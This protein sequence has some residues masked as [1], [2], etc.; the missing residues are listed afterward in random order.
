MAIRFWGQGALVLKFSGGGGG[1]GGC[2]LQNLLCGTWETH[3]PL[4]L[5]NIIQ[6]FPRDPGS[7]LKLVTSSYVTMSDGQR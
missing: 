1:G 5:F 4:Y 3:K 6:E 2:F 7:E